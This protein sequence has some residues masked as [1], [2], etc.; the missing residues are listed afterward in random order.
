M[1]SFKDLFSCMDA[2]TLGIVSSLAIHGF[3]LV[4][5]LLIPG[6]CLKAMPGTIQIILGYQDSF[7]NAGSRKEAEPGMSKPAPLRKKIPPRSNKTKDLPENRPEP[8]VAEEH[9]EVSAERKGPAESSAWHTAH[10]FAAADAGKAGSG[11]DPAQSNGGNA[12]GDSVVE[13]G[14]GMS[15][16][17]AFIY[18]AIPL[19]PPLAKRMGKE[20]RVVL[21]LLIDRHGRLQNIEVLETDGFGFQEAAIAAVRKS[22]FRPAR[23]NGETVSAKAILPIRF[24]LN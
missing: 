9:H 18:Q 22:T 24:R 13:A 23:R 8:A 14:F 16:A 6:A 12:G 21:R 4:L 1:V 17:P 2:Q 19:Y 5:L 7:S 15:G 11:P 3:L 20:G 10:G